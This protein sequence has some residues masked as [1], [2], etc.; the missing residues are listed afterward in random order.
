MV[1]TAAAITLATHAVGNAIILYQIF[2]PLLEHD[3][4]DMVSLGYYRLLRNL[5]LASKTS[6][7]I[8]FVNNILS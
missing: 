8:S 7:D 2:S 3:A 6:S 4:I 5:S 1:P